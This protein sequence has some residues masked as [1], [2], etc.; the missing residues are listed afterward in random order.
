MSLQNLQAWGLTTLSLLVGAAAAIESGDW[1]WFSRSGAAVVAVGIVLTSHQIFE[2]NQRLVEHQRRGQRFHSPPPH[3]AHAHDWADENSIR[4]LIRAR[5]HEE[6]NWRREFSGFR[7]LVGGTLV[8]GFG[9]LVGLL[10]G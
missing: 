9:D 10:F 1:S 6:E 5:T 8:W 7:M 4:Q 3:D 2:H